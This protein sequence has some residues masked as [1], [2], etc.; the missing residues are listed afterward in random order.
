MVVAQQSTQSDLRR[1]S[2]GAARRVAAIDAEARLIL[3]ELLLRRRIDFGV[4][5]APAS[6]TLQWE[7]ELRQIRLTFNVV[8]R[9]FVAPMRRTHGFG[10][11]VWR[12]GS[13]FIVSHSELRIPGRP[14]GASS[15]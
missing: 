2:I 10:V 1:V 15:P 14:S 13:A 7:Y 9:E 11:N 5:A 4:V 3:R 12:T 6:M 8:E